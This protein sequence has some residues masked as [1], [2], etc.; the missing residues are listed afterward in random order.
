[1]TNAAL[2][3]TQVA[4]DRRLNVAALLPLI[5]TALAFAAV[6]ARPAA[7]LARDWWTDPEAG[8]GLLLAPAALWLAWKRGL[9]K[10]PAAQPLLGLVILVFACLVRVG[11][12]LAAELFTMRA[13]MVLAIVGLVTFYLGFR[14][15]LAWWLP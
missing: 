15:V 3:N 14:Q 12:E 2:T 11:A 9:V 6:F 13:A 4:D 8:H 7:L 1:M 10:T 5:L